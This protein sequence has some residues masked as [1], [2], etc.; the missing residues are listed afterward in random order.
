MS[1]NKQSCKCRRVAGPDAYASPLDSDVD[2]GKAGDFY[3]L[4]YDPANPNVEPEYIVLRRPD[5]INGGAIPIKRGGGTDRHGQS[6]WN[7][8][9]N[10][11]QPSLT[12][13]I[14]WKDT[15][16]DQWHGFLIAGS[17]KSC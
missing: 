9:G 15:H 2:P 11:D 17:L 7:W 13:S 10:F 8:D 1:E 12:P 16:R 5:G 14:W 3:F 6:C 4:P